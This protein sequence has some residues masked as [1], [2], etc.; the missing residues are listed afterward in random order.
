MSVYRIALAQMRAAP[1]PAVNLRGAI[2]AVEEAA[3][4][5]AR[6]VCLPELFRTRYFCQREEA[7]RFELA[8]TIPGE[9]TEA[10]GAV[11]RRRGITVIAPIFERRAPG[12]YHNTAAVIGP[13]GA[14]LGLY[15]KMHVPDDP[16]FCEKF[17]FA[18]GDLGFPVFAGPSGPLAVLICWDQ[19][20][21]EAARLAALQGATVIFYPTAIGRLREETEAEGQ[22]QREA[23]RTVQRGHAIANGLYVAAVNRVGFEPAEALPHG[24]PRADKEI[25]RPG[26]A[27]E[28]AHGIEFW[29]GSFL[30]DPFGRLIAEAPEKEEALVVAEIDPGRVEAVRRQWPFLRD[31]RTEAYAGLQRRFLDERPA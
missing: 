1:D 30:C 28:P 10:L 3:A 21:P 12:L 29:G 8:E 2:A 22:A 4:R 17:Y 25:R 14:L 16:G 20:Y 19:W 26:A 27:S 24:P 5:S 18:P 7:A 13:E 15:R 11:A 31:R 9:T 23:W 6:V